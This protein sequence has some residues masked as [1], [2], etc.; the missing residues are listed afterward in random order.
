ML[1]ME[2]GCIPSTSFIGFTA[3]CSIRSEMCLGAGRWMMIPV[4]RGSAFRAWMEDSSSSW[5]M[6]SGKFRSSKPMPA[7]AARRFWLRT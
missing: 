5:V 2:A 4:T 1:P 7:S 3:A 6:V